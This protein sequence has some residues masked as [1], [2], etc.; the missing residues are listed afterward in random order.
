MSRRIATGVGLVVLVIILSG[1]AARQFL[2]KQTEE[3]IIMARY[4]V[5][6]VW[7]DSACLQYPSFS[8]REVCRNPETPFY[9]G[10]FLSEDGENR[11]IRLA[12]DNNTFIVSVYI[13]VGVTVD[14]IACDNPPDPVWAERYVVTEA[15][16]LDGRLAS[17]T[18]QRLCER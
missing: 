6:A 16:Y 9:P 10:E 13:D 8:D 5:L 3:A 1:L 7:P 4:A 12:S 11:Y 2:P 15:H 14:V 17:L 18:L